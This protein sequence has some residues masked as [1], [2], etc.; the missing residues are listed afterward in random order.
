MPSTSRALTHWIFPTYSWSG[1]HYGSHFTDD[2]TRL[3]E[4]EYLVCVP[5]LT[6]SLSNRPQSHQMGSTTRKD[7]Q[8]SFLE[9]KGWVFASSGFWI[10]IWII[11]YQ[12]N[13]IIMMMMMMVI[14]IMFPHSYP[15]RFISANLS[16][17]WEFVF[18]QRSLDESDDHPGLRSMISSVPFCPQHLNETSQ[19]LVRDL[20]GTRTGHWVSGK[21]EA[22]GWHG[23]PPPDC[24]PPLIH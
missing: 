22:P 6:S 19:A 24:F 12:N 21:W 8:S 5:Q 20:C 17:A 3:R 13:I 4:A 1:H 16:G 10:W 11:G 18:S 9:N 14:I 23:K 2:K 15:Q 7:V